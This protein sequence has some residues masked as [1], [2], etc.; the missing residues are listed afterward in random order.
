MFAVVAVF[1]GVGCGAL[2]RWGLGLCL[3]PLV[4]TLLL[5]TLTANLLAQSKTTRYSTQM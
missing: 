4:P 5:G 1:S 3:N 2:P